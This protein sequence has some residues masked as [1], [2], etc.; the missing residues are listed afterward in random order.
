MSQILVCSNSSA[1]YV[2]CNFLKYLQKHTI[3]WELPT[4]LALH[5][6]KSTDRSK[7]TASPKTAIALP[8][9]V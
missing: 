9:L 4:I 7:H 2:Y 6:A 8:P 5:H 1:V 3:D